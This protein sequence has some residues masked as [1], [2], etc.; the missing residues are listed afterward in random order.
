MTNLE[1]LDEDDLVRVLK[2]DL[3]LR[4][5]HAGNHFDNSL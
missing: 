4:L 5:D 2:V 3:V 1:Y